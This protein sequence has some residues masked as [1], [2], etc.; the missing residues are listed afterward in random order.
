MNLRLKRHH[1]KTMIEIFYDSDGGSCLVAVTHEDNFLPYPD[2]YKKLEADD[3]ATVDMKI[4]EGDNDD[5][6]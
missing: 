4:L 2:L 5:S 6:E 3:E 1:D